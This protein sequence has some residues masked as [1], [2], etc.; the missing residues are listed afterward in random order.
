MEVKSEKFDFGFSTESSRFIFEAE[1]E[2]VISYSE[3]KK[4][5]PKE[6][7]DFEKQ[8]NT[9]IQKFNHEFQSQSF[10]ME[11]CL[12]YCMVD[13]KSSRFY[14]FY[15]DSDYLGIGIKKEYKFDL[16]EEVLNKLKDS[17]DDVLFEFRLKTNITLGYKY[18]NHSK[19]KHIFYLDFFDLFNL[20]SK[21]QMLKNSGVSFD[22][23][24]WVKKEFVQ[25]R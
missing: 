22:L 11:D 24:K 13:E 18:L 17:F 8:C 2:A 10:T 23:E 14:F 9:V 7:S 20:S 15:T 19:V 3:L 1:M 5:I 12:E 16:V 6:I 25:G 4:V 21:A